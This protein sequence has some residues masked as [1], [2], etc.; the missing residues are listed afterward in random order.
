M[1]QML[2]PFACV[3]VSVCSANVNGRLKRETTRFRVVHR[4]RRAAFWESAM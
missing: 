1:T 2:E 3:A 4:M